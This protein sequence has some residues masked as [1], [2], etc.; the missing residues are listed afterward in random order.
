[1][2]EN[3]N[4]PT[5]DEIEEV[6]DD[7]E[8]IEVDIRDVAARYMELES[9]SMYVWGRRRSG[10]THM[11]KWMLY[12][13]TQMGLEYDLV[14]LFSG[15]TCKDQFPMISRSFQYEGWTNESA[16]V[17]DRLIAR[18]REILAHNAECT[19]E[20]EKRK[21]GRCLVI[22]DDVLGSDGQLWQ[23]KKA[24][25]LSSLFFQGRHHSIDVWLLTQ[26]MSGFRRVMSN[27]DLLVSWR[28]NSAEQRK[29]IRVAH[30]TCEEG[31]GVEV[32]R[33]AESFLER[34][35]KGKHG[36][37]VIDLAGSHSK[38]SLKE[39]VFSCTCPEDD[40]PTFGVGPETHW[41]VGNDV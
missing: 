37:S 33:R 14:L 1:M 32:G 15:T 11:V 13:L 19:E 6:L 30:C 31:G 34:S 18:Q 9:G 41:T 7:G 5:I 2:S 38:H 8:P 36:A 40:V 39:Y 20:S 23:G 22:L 25:T 24:G 27:S 35:W 12:S 28:S 21:L 29:E 3:E 16:Q 4:K 26:T 17:I 10:K